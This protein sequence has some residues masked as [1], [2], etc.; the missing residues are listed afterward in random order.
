M[1]YVYVVGSDNLL[2][3]RRVTMGPLQGDGLRVIAEGLKPNEI[4]VVGGLQQVRPRMEIKPDRTPMP[5]LGGNKNTTPSD[6]DGKQAK[7]P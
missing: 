3:Y 1:K 7:Q 4:E 5:Q 6:E 2:E